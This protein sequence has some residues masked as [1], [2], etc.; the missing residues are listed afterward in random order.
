MTCLMF[1]LVVWT[2]NNGELSGQM[3]V[4]PLGILCPLVFFANMTFND[5]RVIFETD[6]YVVL[7]NVSVGTSSSCHFSVLSF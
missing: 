6:L 1:Y 7:Y 4:R 2:W 5:H 3:A